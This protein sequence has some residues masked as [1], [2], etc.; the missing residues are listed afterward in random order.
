MERF[1]GRTAVVTGGASGIGLAMARRFV[2]EGM[3]VVIADVEQAALDTA[4]AELGGGGAEVLGV[5]TDVRHA[6]EV[7]ALAARVAE[8]FGAWDLVC[9]NAGVGAGGTT[10]EQTVADWEWVLGVNLWGV[11]HGIRAF[12]PT[13]V[14]RN[15][16][17]VVLTASLAGHVA[18]PR[19]VS[20]NASKY[21]VVAIG[22]TLHAELAE[23]APG[24]GV[25]I[26]CPAWVNTRIY[27]SGRNRPEDLGEP[28][29]PDD[30]SLSEMRRFFAAS[31]DPAEVA[32]RVVEGVVSRR[33]FLFT[34]EFSAD[35][36]RD[37]VA[38]MFT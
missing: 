17:H 16:G 9:L 21:A 23:H 15:D 7:D 33:L 13:M 36:I 3:R 22:E 11:I 4:V 31:M 25:S 27:E 29:E 37:R 20:Y 32:E 30:A 10:W 19:T 5:R 34:H 38:R 26:L 28:A 8:A 18:Q 6:D 2:A 12:V 14:E 24:V 35:V 1:E